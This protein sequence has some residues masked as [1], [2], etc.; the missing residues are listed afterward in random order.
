MRRLGYRQVADDL[1]AQIRSGQLR[2]G[3]RVPSEVDLTQ[4]YT[5]GLETARR[6][7]RLLVAEGLLVKTPN[8]PTRVAAPV[9]RTE[10]RKPRQTQV[11]SRPPTAEERD[12]HGDTWML[13]A[14]LY[15]RVV[16]TY[17]ASRFYITIH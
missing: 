17:P 15:G 8:Y 16:G 7:V 5:V 4:I 2:P 9:E 10:I 14:S 13:V 12:E 6:A 1:R 11:Y 3:D